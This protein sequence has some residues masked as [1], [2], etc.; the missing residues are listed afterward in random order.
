MDTPVTHE[1]Y[2]VFQHSPRLGASI[3]FAP[4]LVSRLIERG[5]SRRKELLTNFLKGDHAD[6]VELQRR[7]AAY[8]G[9]EKY[10]HGFFYT[11]TKLGQQ[12]AVLDKHRFLDKHASEILDTPYPNELYKRYKTAIIALQHS[13]LIANEGFAAWLELHILRRMNPEIHAIIPEREE[14]MRS[15]QTLLDLRRTSCYFS[16]FPPPPNHNSPYEEGRRL[17]DSIEHFYPP[18]EVYGVRCAIQAFLVATAIPLGITNGEGAP[19]FAMEPGELEQALLEKGGDHARSELR[20][21]RISRVLED[22]Q[23]T[24]QAAQHQLQCYATCPHSECPV[25]AQ[26]AKKLGWRYTDDAE[27]SNL[28]FD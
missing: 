2:W 16:Q 10:G 3:P 6:A 23:E 20:L 9:H 27:K 7:I 26:I 18:H 28:R 19:R 11:C 1:T 8:L 14:F 4:D 24:V 25:R 13:A 15:S 22:S 17:L 21:W 5:S 12:L